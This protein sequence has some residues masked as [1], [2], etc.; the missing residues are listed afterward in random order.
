VRRLILVAL[1][2]VVVSYWRSGT[3]EIR[4]P[5]DV[6]SSSTGIV[7]RVVDGDTLE[8]ED[9]R[10][11]RLLG[12]DTPETKHPD[13][14][15][16]RGGP[17]AAAWTKT[18]IERRP[19]RLE[20][21]RERRDRHGRWLAYVFDATHASTTTATAN[22]ATGAFLNEELVRAGWSRADARFPLRSEYLRRL[23]EAE[24]EAK[25]AGRGLWHPDSP[26]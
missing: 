18:R 1:L 13:K 16:E 3:D 19:V 8:L 4:V 11:V 10:R 7:R 5:D 2:V 6:A 26:R 9:G 20:F 14:P 21:D 12:V 15:V 23:R 25:D 24:Q 22:S 17:E